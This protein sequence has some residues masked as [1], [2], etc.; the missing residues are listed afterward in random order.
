MAQPGRAPQAAVFPINIHWN[1]QKGWWITPQSGRVPLNDTVQ[2]N[3]DTDCTVY[4]DP[5]NTVFGASHNVNVGSSWDVPV[6][7]INC[8]VSLC[9]TG[10][11]DPPCNPNVRIADSMGT[12]IVGSGGEDRK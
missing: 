9:A 7:N 11:S 3:A 12:I 1:Q 6:G 5:T 10:Q 2:F 4:F 8:T